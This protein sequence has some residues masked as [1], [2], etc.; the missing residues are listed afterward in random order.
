MQRNQLFHLGIIN[1]LTRRLAV[2]H[3]L[4]IFPS[5]KIGLNVGV[6]PLEIE[7]APIL[8]ENDQ[9]VLLPPL[10]VL[11]AFEENLKDFLV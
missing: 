5:L 3:L 1:A 10:P 6:E 2:C 4:Q 9:T 7:T 8:N 11:D